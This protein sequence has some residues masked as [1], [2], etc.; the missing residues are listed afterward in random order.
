MTAKVKEEPIGDKPVSSS[1]R[2]TDD[3]L[4]RHSTQ[5]RNWSFTPERL[6]Q[7]R[8]E[9]NAS[10]G[11]KA[12]KTLKQFLESHPELS[13]EEEEAVASK[14]VPVT[15]HEELLLVNYFAR[16]IISFAGKMNLPTEVAATAVAFFRRFF[17][18]NSVMDIPPKEVF[19][20]TLFFA[21]KTENY[22]IGVE[23]F[24]KKAKTTTDAILKHEFKLLESL[25]FTLMN[26]HPYKALHGF[27]L[28]IQNVLS[29]RVDM[30]Y[31]GQVYTN[32][33]KSIS[34]ALLTDAVYF[35]TPPQITLAILLMEDEALMMRYMQLKF[36][37]QP[38]NGDGS[39]QS[40]Q[41]SEQVSSNGIN[42]SK[43]LEVIK[44]CRSVINN[45]IIPAKDDAVKITAKIHYC[46]NP[47]AVIDRL[48]RQRESSSIASTPQPV[49]TDSKRQ[50]T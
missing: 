21:C 35:Y 16:M 13:R 34:D 44:S 4:Y 38:D 32:C 29:G 23:S 5:Y 25:N 15:T 30:K 19:H 2:I 28:D 26:H 47:M 37:L 9:V 43:L 50:K 7:I 10:A 6:D 1:L 36:G 3:D 49:E 14:A 33:K 31:M 18:S 40:S 39:G 46:Q 17:L 42:A 41:D 27:F 8:T 45:K 12:E 24:A 11:S 48:K 20:T 22:F